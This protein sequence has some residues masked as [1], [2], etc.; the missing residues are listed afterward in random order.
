MIKSLL[1]YV[2][3][4]MLG[5]AIFVAIVAAGTYFLQSSLI[6]VR[7]YGSYTHWAVILFCLPVVAGVVNRLLRV[8][9]PL[10]CCAIG[11][12]VS[13]AI[14]YPQYTR[15]WA[16]PPTLT[17]IVI[18]LCIVFGIGYIATQP[19]TA[20]FMLA[21][22]LGRYSVPDFVKPGKNKRKSGGNGNK[23]ANQYT[24]T[25]PIY[26]NHGNVVAMMELVIGVCSLGLSIFSVF[27]L[28]RS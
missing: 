14:L 24:N 3:S 6:L 16:E 25:Q 10:F 23:S 22:K 15:L 28:G 26:S 11:S 13:A 7:H 4:I 2:R 27:F 8:Q 17:N 19:L 21:F 5:A 18:Y 9:F 12:L 1:A 20:T